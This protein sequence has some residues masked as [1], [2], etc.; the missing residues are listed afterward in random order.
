MGKSLDNEIDSFR[1]TWHLM[2]INDINYFL[3]KN[4]TFGASILKETNHE[5]RNYICFTPAKNVL[6]VT[7]KM[8]N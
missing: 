1:F 5:S 4:I 8:S 7:K 3:Q 6:I 2:P